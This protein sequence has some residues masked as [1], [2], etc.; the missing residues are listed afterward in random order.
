MRLSRLVLA[1]AG[2]LAAASPSWGQVTPAATVNGSITITAG[3][4]FQQVLAVIGAPP[5]PRRS[6]TIQNN[7]T[8]GDNCWVFIGATATATKATSMLLGPGGSYQRYFPYLPSDNIA[9][10]CATTSDTLYVDTQ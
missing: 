5:T 1:V 10:T 8:N 4:T 2:L 6:I 9:A 3:N 7:N